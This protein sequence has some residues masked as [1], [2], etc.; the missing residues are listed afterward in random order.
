VPTTDLLQLGS[1][2]AAALLVVLWR[3]RVRVHRH[4][5]RLAEALADAERRAREIERFRGITRALLEGRELA[6]V[7]NTVARA[8]ADLTGALSG[9][10]SLL[11]DG[12]RTLRLAAATGPLER[13]VGRNLPREGS[14]AGWV[15]E[16]GAPLLINDLDLDQRAY[17]PVN[18]EYGF[19]RGLMVPLLSRG[20][21][22]GALGADAGAGHR[23][24]EPHDA[25]LLERLAEQ[26]VLA[27]ESAQLFESGQ[28]A[29]AHLAAKNEE[30]ERAMASK[31]A[32]LTNVSH[33]LR[34]PL[35]SIIGFS[36][37]LA[38]GA[39]GALSEC[40]ADYL[41]TVVRNS[42][43]LLGLINDLLDL[44]K[45]E[46]GKMAL[47]LT[48]TDMSA[49][50]DGLVRDAEGLTAQRRLKL[51]REVGTG[52]LQVLA[53]EVRVRQVLFNFL[54]NA[55]RFTPDGGEVVIRA[56]GTRAPLPVPAERAGDGTPLRTRDAVW[57]AV[58]D[59]GPGIRP[60][61]M[62]KL[63]REFSQVDESLSR[64]K[65]GT[66]LGLALSKRLI[67][68]HGGTV[69]AESVFGQG[70]TFWFILPIEGPVRQ[71]LPRAA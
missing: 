52:S 43:H 69:G 45:V 33:E 39:V 6:G 64:A 27:I 54:S 28:L 12:G 53:D 46:A 22:V 30:L 57:V 48:P 70:S 44:S 11:A 63:F 34:T 62:P 41:S 60:E 21:M 2:L 5:A 47:H 14:M 8:A 16:H 4:A 40:Q 68:L 17:S 59:T 71:T 31:T 65:G 51:V 35:N 10:I 66:G 1:L 32:F 29:R 18:R 13:L 49:L 42:R 61:D 67:E 55:V 56:I 19:A 37:L 9:H 38:T 58:S 36:E 3:G 50:I 25:D 15:I 20:E 24:F 7:L 23:P 26:A